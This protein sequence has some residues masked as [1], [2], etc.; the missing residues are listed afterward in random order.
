[1]VAGVVVEVEVEVEVWSNLCGNVGSSAACTRWQ[2][3]GLHAIIRVTQHR[4]GLCKY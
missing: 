3:V 4:G 2:V 1:M